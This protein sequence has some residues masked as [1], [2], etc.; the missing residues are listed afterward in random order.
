MHQPTRRI[1]Q[2]NR[3]KILD[4]PNSQRRHINRTLE[5]NTSNRPSS[6]P[7]TSLLHETREILMCN[8]ETCEYTPTLSRGANYI[9]QCSECNHI[10]QLSEAIVCPKCKA[11][12]LIWKEQRQNAMTD[13]NK[14]RPDSESTRNPNKQEATETVTNKQ[15]QQTTRTPTEITTVSQPSSRTAT[16]SRATMRGKLR[17]AQEQ[18]SCARRDSL[19]DTR[20]YRTTSAENR[21]YTNLRG[22]LKVLPLQIP[23]PRSMKT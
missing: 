8:D 20:A 2:S 9:L 13:S 21:R 22:T 12:I 4:S 23:T 7:R 11:G 3:P 5:A 15:Q 1:R 10:E 18:T 17:R 16:I 6:T 19:R 14:T